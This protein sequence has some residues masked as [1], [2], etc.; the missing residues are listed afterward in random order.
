M[1]F[2]SGKKIK[3]FTACNKTYL[4]YAVALSN[5]VRA[6]WGMNL[7][8]YTINC[9]VAEK[10]NFI[11]ILQTMEDR[12]VGKYSW[13]AAFCMRYRGM[14]FYE[15]LRAIRMFDKT[16]TMLF[17][18]DADSI[19]RKPV[20]DL[21]KYVADATVTA[22]QKSEN[23]YASGVLGISTNALSF[24]KTYRTLVN[25]D[26]HWKSDQRNLAKAL[27]LHKHDVTFRPLPERFCDTA[28]TDEGVI[29]TA[30]IKCHDDPKWKKEYEYYLS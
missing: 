25:G 1:N 26:E 8:V 14:V 11:P 30:K 3:V 16:E 4:D 27:S 9:N 17:W 12:W 5:S 10:P 6:N 15:M 18:I 24:A 7:T 22:K 29:W 19:V 13:E 23:E 21:F 20:D 2:S 28:F